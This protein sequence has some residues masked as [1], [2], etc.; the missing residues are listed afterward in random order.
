MPFNFSKVSFFLFLYFEIPDACSKSRLRLFSLSFRISSTRPN[1]IIAYESAETPVSI[2]R[3][4]TSFRRQ[5]TSF[6]RYSLSP[7]RNNLRVIVTVLYS[8]GRTLLVFSKVSET[9]ANPEAFLFFVPL[10]IR[11]SI[12]SRRSIL[13]FCS[14]NT[15]RMASTTFDFPQPFGPTIP[16][17]F[18]LK[19]M[20][21]WSAK[22]LNPLISN[23]V[24]FIN[25]RE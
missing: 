10:K 22:L 13:G 23:C 7:S 14:P 4:L 6:R 20:M 9:S 3:L 2:N 5:A 15:Q 25:T 8:V 17:I 12:F 1:S 19:L 16:V 11:F 24:N 18:S 21:V